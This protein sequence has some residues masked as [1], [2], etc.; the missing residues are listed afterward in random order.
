[1]TRTN[2]HDFEFYVYTKPTSGFGTGTYDRWLLRGAAVEIERSLFEGDLLTITSTRKNQD[3]QID[4]VRPVRFYWKSTKLF[5]GC[6][7]APRYDNRQNK[8]RDLVTTAYGWEKE[9]AAIQLDLVTPEGVQYADKSIDFILSDLARIANDMGMTKKATYVY[10]KTKLPYYDAAIFGTTITRTYG[11]TIWSALKDMTKEL[12]MAETAHIGEWAIKI[13]ALQSDFY[14]Y[15]IPIMVNTDLPAVRKFKENMLTTPKGIRRDYSRLLNYVM[16]R[17][18]G[19]LINTRF[20]PDPITLSEKSI[21]TNSD[22]FYAD[23][24]PSS[25]AYL[26][27]AIK[28]PTSA[29]KGGFVTVNGSDGQLNELTERFHLW[30]RAGQS[31]EHLTNN[32]YATLSGGALKAFVT[33]SWAGCTIKVDEASNAMKGSEIYF[34]V[35]GRS[36]NDFG[37]RGVTIRNINLDTQL[38]VDAYAGQLVRMYHAPLVHIDAAIKPEYANPDELIGKTITLFDNFQNDFSDFTCIK[39]RYYFEGPQVTESIT[40]MRYNYDWEYSE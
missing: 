1:M 2:P 18:A 24:Q 37:V 16:V 10:D 28:N 4:R 31:Q 12:D 35:A 19:T 36:V 20:R 21:V 17:G 9:L 6:I 34:S 13:D 26:R 25:R 15:M 38:K 8:Y 32:R 23:V 27:I 29:D 39:Q 5:D 30:V 7:R 40:A 22:E 3:A 14:I 33:E 11:G